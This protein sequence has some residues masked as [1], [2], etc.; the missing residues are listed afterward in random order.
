VAIIDGG[1][2]IALDSPAELQKKSAEQSSIA[3]KLTQPLRDRAIPNFSEAIQTA[4]SD[5]G[6]EINVT[7]R[8]PARTLVELVKWVDAQGYEV[9]D[10]RVKRPT[11]E[12]VFI[13]MTGQKLR[14]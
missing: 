6:L 3:L 14:D 5:N 11:L 2:I 4:I 1:K 13:E 8:H 12:D 7:S 10:V 9:D